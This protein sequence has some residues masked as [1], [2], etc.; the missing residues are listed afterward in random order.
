MKIIRDFL[1]QSVIKPRLLNITFHGIRESVKMRKLSGLIMITM[2]LT[3]LF[4]G[5]GT[6]EEDTG[7]K[8][9]PIDQNKEQ[10]SFRAEVLESGAS[11]LVTPSKDSNEAKSSDKIS[12]G[13]NDATIVDESGEAMTMDQLKVGDILVITYNGMIAE[14]YPAQIGA[15]RIERVD[16]DNLLDG[17]LALI[18]DI[19]QVD[20][21]LNSEIDTIAFDTSEWIELT[22]TLKELIF[23]K[24]KETYGYEVIEGTFEELKEQG[25]IDEDN[26][27]FPKGILIKI[28]KM[29]Y[30]K[31]KEEITCSIEKWRSGL[32]AIGAEEVT[33]TLKDGKWSITKEGNWIS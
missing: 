3:L 26:L 5:C 6:L 24:V 20:E 14:S 9:A 29:E 19:Y 32:G 7:V 13:Q 21:G 25:L 12:V 18:D 22:K 33:A 16:H 30:D 11:L 2:I 15:D 1:E 8:K 28:T 17:Y 27:Y 23:Q 31:D 10:Y 4:V